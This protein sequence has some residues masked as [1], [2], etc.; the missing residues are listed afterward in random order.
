MDTYRFDR[1]DSCRSACGGGEAGKR[2]VDDVCARRALR[3]S[4]RAPLGAHTHNQGKQRGSG[5]KPHTH[6]T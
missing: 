2:F 3:P 5:R 1:S 4:M 6:E